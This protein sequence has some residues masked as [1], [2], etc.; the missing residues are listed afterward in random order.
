VTAT[1][2][3]VLTTR[4]E[5][6]VVA[7]FLADLAAE[8]VPTAGWQPTSI[9]RAMLQIE[10]RSQAAAEA[11]RLRVVQGG[12]LD[13][14]TGAWLDL[15][16]QGFFGLPRVAA[17]AA[18]H[19][20]RVTDSTAGAALSKQARTVRVR[21]DLTGL[22]F[23]NAE[24]FEVPMSGSTS[25]ADPQFVCETL[26]VGGNVAA[27]SAWTLITSL[28]GYTVTNP[29]IGVTGSSLVTAAVDEETDAALRE[30]CRNRWST[31]GAGGNAAAVAYR[32]TQASTTVTRW[33]ID[34]AN[35]NGPGSLDV[36]IANA[37]GPATSDEVEDVEDYLTPRKAV[38]TGELRVF[39][40]TAHN[41][42]VTATLYTDG[43]SGTVAADAATALSTLQASF[44]LGEPL[45]LAEL[46][47]QLMG[48]DSV[49]NVVIAAPVADVT[50]AIGE[51]L[52][53]SPSP[54]FTVL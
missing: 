53:F 27:S 6:E 24:S 7:D 18:V 17:S 39:A 38:G 52:V 31:L 35:P 36:Y 48:V 34:D 2:A 19:K 41:V 45:Y 40:A 1:L 21:H 12:Y 11:I 10:A 3:T 4:T 47:Q 22:T 5:A 51:A 54:S 46:V 16:A 20:F 30:R 14:A 28:P 50:L 9:Q 32:I 42:A 33:Q 13:T 8:D 37:S 23:I 44:A 43:S 29:A 25:G 26:G 49:I 15:L